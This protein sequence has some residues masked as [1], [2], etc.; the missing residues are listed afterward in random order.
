[1]ATKISKATGNFSAA[2]TW[3]PIDAG[4][5]LDSEAGGTAMAGDGAAYN[6]N[7]PWLMLRKNAALGLNATTVLATWGGTPGTWANLSGSTPLSTDAGAW[8]CFVD[9]DG[10][11]GWV[12][13]DDWTVQ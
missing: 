11:A 10:T 13:V 1:M 12:N 8:E 3:A 6:G 9:C 5:E 2:T 7:P 4:S